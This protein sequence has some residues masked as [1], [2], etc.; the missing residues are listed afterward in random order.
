MQIAV[1]QRTHESKG[2]KHVEVKFFGGS[3]EENIKY[4]RTHPGG[5]EGFRHYNENVRKMKQTI[6]T[7]FSKF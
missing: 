2:Q 1:Q 6:K 5:K 7:Y 3:R 4:I